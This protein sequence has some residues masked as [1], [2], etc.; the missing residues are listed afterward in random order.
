MEETHTMEEIHQQTRCNQND[1]KKK[2]LIAALKPPEVTEAFTT[3]IKEAFRECSVKEKTRNN[4][5]KLRIE[6]S[7]ED[8]QEVKKE[9]TSPTIPTNT[10]TDHKTENDKTQRKV[11]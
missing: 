8:K 1:K 3:S 7:R 11:K 10:A 2:I 9:E 5:N 4:F 6:T